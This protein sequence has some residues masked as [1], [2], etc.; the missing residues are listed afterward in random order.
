MSARTSPP[1]LA[2]APLW[3]PPA[4]AEAIESG[5]KM[6]QPSHP[7]WLRRC[8]EGR[9]SMA[10]TDCRWQHW[11]SLG[12]ERGRVRRV[13]RGRSLQ[14]GRPHRHGERQAH[15]ARWPESP[16]RLKSL[17]TQPE[18]SRTRVS[19]TQLEPCNVHTTP[20]AP[21]HVGAAV[22]N[23]ADAFPEEVRVSKD[24]A[25]VACIGA[26]D[27]P[28]CARPQLKPTGHDVQRRDTP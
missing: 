6:A 24:G 19:S 25:R 11:R 14:H 10:G 5:I 9:S 8:S 13:A 20:S 18:Y 22:G 23:G 2:Q 17:R 7:R 12:Y 21:I 27:P 26:Q 4:A 1:P 28:V 15:A 3:A 16:L